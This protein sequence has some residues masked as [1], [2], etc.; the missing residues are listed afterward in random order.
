MTFDVFI[1]HPHQNKAI[2]DAACA[3][4]E[5]AGIR[6]WIAPRDI[7][8]GADWGSSI[9][10]AIA[11]AEVMV[12]VF[13][14]HANASEQIK[15]EVERAV[16]RGIPI[17]PL[18]TEDVPMSTAL[19]YFLSTS[20]WLDALTPPLDKHLKQLTIAVR[21]LLNLRRRA[22]NNGGQPKAGVSDR[23]PVT[24]I[25]VAASSPRL[26]AG[27]PWIY[28]LALLSAGLLAGLAIP[29]L[30]RMQLVAT[31]PPPICSDSLCKTIWDYKLSVPMRPYLGVV[32]TLRFLPNNRWTRDAPQGRPPDE[33]SNGTYSLQG[34]TLV[35]KEDGG[36]EWTGTIDGNQISGT[37]GIATA[38]N[39]A[40]TDFP[41]TATL[42]AARDQQP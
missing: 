33:A 13:S 14:Q 9:V 15:R 42:R 5:A 23:P 17:I 1:S 36:R 31:A 35:F 34:N 38:R 21:E 30:M 12:L 19:Q 2:A 24:R 10:E 28:T 32:S 29:F 39:S 6:C 22:V 11:A 37:I 40:P 8:P 25:D 4:L 16:N 7:I 18:R 3:H 27:R 41:W 20:H 26:R